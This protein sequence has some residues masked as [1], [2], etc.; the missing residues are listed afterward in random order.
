MDPSNKQER[1]EMGRQIHTV[2]E[3]MHNCVRRKLEDAENSRLGMADVTDKT[4][5]RANPGSSGRR[6][7]AVRREFC[8]QRKRFPWTAPAKPT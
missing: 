4:A 8:A 2:K 3:K 7:T 6:A 1:N 5:M